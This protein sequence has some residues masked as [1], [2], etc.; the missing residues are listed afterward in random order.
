MAIIR[1]IT[2][3]TVYGLAEKIRALLFPKTG[4]CGFCHLPKPKN[5]PL[6]E[7]GHLSGYIPG[8]SVREK[9]RIQIG[10]TLNILADIR[11]RW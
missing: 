1:L 10:V 3:E 11:D 5:C 2:L 7:M 4:S 8:E 9:N 6:K